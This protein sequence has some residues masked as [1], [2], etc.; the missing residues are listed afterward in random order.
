MATTLSRPNSHSTLWDH[1]PLEIQANLA[2]LKEYI[3]ILYVY[4][5]HTLTLVVVNKF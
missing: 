2:S 3:K 4:A 5:M 1:D